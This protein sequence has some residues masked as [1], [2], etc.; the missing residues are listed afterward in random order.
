MK[1]TLSIVFLSITSL[2]LVGCW[3]QFEKT[4]PSVETEIDADT[5]E[6]VNEVDT[7]AVEEIVISWWN[8]EIMLQDKLDGILSEYCLDIAWW[9]QNVDPDNGLQVHTC[10]SYK[11]ELWTDQVFDMTAFAN[12]S[13]FMPIYDVCV[14]FDS[15]EAGSEVSLSACGESASAIEFSGNW[16]ITPVDAPDLCFTANDESRMWRWSQHQ[17]RDLT[18]ETCTESKSA[19][20]MWIVRSIDW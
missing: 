13:L 4:T 18:L 17:I 10:Y 6:K 14:S 15:L 11:G 7:Q 3:G 16:T 9:N 12:N 1:K 20:Q 5:F 8:V 2:M 19:Y